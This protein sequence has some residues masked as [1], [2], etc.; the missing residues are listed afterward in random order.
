MTRRIAMW[1]GPR[2]ISTAMMRSWENRPDCSVVDEPFYAAYLAATGVE[3]PCREEILKA[4]P[5]SY[6]EVVR[7]LTEG[8]VL[9]P[10][11]YQ[12]HMTH[13]IPE[14]MD[15]AWCAGLCHCFLI[16]DPAQVIASYLQRMPAADEDA[17]GIRRQA[18]LFDE[19]TAA[20]GR[21]PAVIDSNDVLQN[22]G[23]VLQAL[24][25]YLEIPF[26]EHAML[27]WPAGPRTSDGVWA[28]HWYHNVER[29]TGFAASSPKS[30]GLTGEHL[31][32][33]TRMQTLYERLAVYRIRP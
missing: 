29:S 16:R 4:Q 15:M 33:A 1:S 11:Q 9:S 13:H 28:S 19:I 18:D 10:L 22:P 8:P 30:P 3:H 14:G 21:R 12:K 32:L 5:R 6:A 17:I 25:Q 24:C 2:N 31:A 23:K 20:T 27:S 7:Q 26:S